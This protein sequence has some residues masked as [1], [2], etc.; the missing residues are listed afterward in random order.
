MYA[1]PL[2]VHYTFK[3]FNWKNGFGHTET[4]KGNTIVILK[5]RLYFET[6]SNSRW[7]FK[8]W[9][10]PCGGRQHLKSYDSNGIAYYWFTQK[11]SK[12]NFRG[13]LR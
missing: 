12:W 11:Q 9:K 10:A 4:G 6:Q 13:K 7:L 5:K 2:K 3:E 1:I 8:I